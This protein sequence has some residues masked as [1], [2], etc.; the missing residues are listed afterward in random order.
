MPGHPM[1][2]QNRIQGIEM[3]GQVSFVIQLVQ[4]SMA[5]LTNFNTAITGL[6]TMFPSNISPVMNFSGN[7]VMAGQGAQR[8]A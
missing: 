5:D 1:V 7:Q 2:I 6:P 4:A 8:A 3:P